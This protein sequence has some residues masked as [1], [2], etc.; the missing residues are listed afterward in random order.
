MFGTG[1]VHAR[2]VPCLPPNG[3]CPEVPG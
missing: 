3:L 2:P 1:K